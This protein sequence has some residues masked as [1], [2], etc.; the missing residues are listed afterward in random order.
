[1]AFPGFHPGLS[2]FA[3][4]GS[5]CMGYLGF[6]ASHPFHDEAVKWMGHTHLRL[7]GSS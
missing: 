2:S 6:G 1:M 4:Y 3:P 5:G 7:V